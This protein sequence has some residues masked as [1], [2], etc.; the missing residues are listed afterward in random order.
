MNNLEDF[1]KKHLKN[2]SLGNITEKVKDNTKKID[3][4]SVDVNKGIQLMEGIEARSKE[5][6]EAITEMVGKINLSTDSSP[7]L[8]QHLLTTYMKMPKTSSVAVVGDRVLHHMMLDNP[9]LR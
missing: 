3:I 6:H 4:L 1:M 9:S 8:F 7:S 2:P 5:T